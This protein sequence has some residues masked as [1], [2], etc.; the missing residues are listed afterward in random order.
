MTYQ[1]QK[2][3]N[4]K[5]S[6]WIEEENHA[7]MRY[8]SLSA[9][10]ILRFQRSISVVTCRMWT[11]TTARCAGM[12]PTSPLWPFTAH[13]CFDGTV[14]YNA[15]RI[16]VHSN[17]ETNQESN[18]QHALGCA[19]KVVS[20]PHRHQA[21]TITC[22]LPDCSPKQ[23]RHARQNTNNDDPSARN[24]RRDKTR[25]INLRFVAITVFL[26]RNI[27]VMYTC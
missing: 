26:S 16:V 4:F 2:I 7:L 22:L 1:F 25:D 13:A 27:T 3:N 20:S 12:L 17:Q 14:T 8:S 19:R 18:S 21:V 6:N 23:T 5:T 10:L 15:Y 9:L 24:S 11:N